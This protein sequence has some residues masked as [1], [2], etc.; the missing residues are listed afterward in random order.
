M[1]DSR[2]R[3]NIEL[4]AAIKKYRPVFALAPRRVTSLR[5][6]ASGIEVVWASIIISVLLFYIIHRDHFHGLEL[7]LH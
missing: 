3:K 7:P 1:Y 5:S 2:N 4:I 6:P